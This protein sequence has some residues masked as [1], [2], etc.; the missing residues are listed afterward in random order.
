MDNQEQEKLAKSKADF[1][2]KKDAAEKAAWEYFCACDAGPDREFA[3]EM[4][5]RILYCTRR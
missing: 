4:Y 1:L 3:H 2:Q 5:S